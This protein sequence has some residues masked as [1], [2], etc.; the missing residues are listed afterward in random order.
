MKVIFLQ[1]VKGKGK[2]G[3][4]KNVAEGYARNY[5]IP[6]GLASVAN[7]S[8]MKQLQQQ[9]KAEAKRKEDEKKKAEETARKMKEITLEIPAKA[10]EGGAFSAP[11]PTSRSR[12]C[13][14]KTTR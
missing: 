14:K 5:L 3:E 12:K 6:R 1:D 10:G 11:S 9:N 2:K 7:E 4:V 13:C 8:N